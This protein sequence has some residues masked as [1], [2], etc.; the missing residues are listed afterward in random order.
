MEQELI[1]LK[2][3]FEIINKEKEKREDNY[4]EAVLIK[5]DPD[6]YISKKLEQTKAE[7]KHRIKE[8]ERLQVLLQEKESTIRSITMAHTEFKYQLDTMKEELFYNKNEKENLSRKL[9]NIE[10][11]DNKT[12]TIQNESLKDQNRKLLQTLMKLLKT[13]EEVTKPSS[14][15][16]T[17]RR[18]L[19][20]SMKNSTLVLGNIHR[21]S[22]PSPSK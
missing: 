1:T 4:Q 18:P 11:N 5:N 15:K 10:K 3:K 6:S 8:N 7:I 20:N 2:K 9:N 16:K 13:N 14:S 22:S 21:L 12:V 19:S 17:V